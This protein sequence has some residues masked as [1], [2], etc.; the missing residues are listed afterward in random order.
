M[1]PLYL[2][3][4]H[5][6]RSVA[7]DLKQP[8]GR[9]VLFRLLH[10][11]DVFV[12]NVRAPALARLGLAYDDLRTAL[13]GADLRSACGFGS[14]GRYAGRPAYDDLIQGAAALPTLA[15]RAGAEEPLYAP[16]VFADE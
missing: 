2:H 4:N 11:A 3:A 9:E 10:D 1:G 8:R 7:I 15:E 6:K 5:N 13:P 12:S 14:D 16:S